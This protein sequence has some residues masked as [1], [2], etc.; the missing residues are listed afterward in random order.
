MLKK[1]NN[2]NLSKYSYE[3]IEK[4][5]E[6]IKNM[7][8]SKYRNDLKMIKKIIVKNN[9]DI[10]MIKNNNGYFSPDFETLTHK[11]Y[12]ELTNYFSQMDNISKN[13]N[14]NFS[15][16]HD[17]KNVSEIKIEKKYKYTNSENHILNKIKYEKALNQHRNECKNMEINCSKDNIFKKK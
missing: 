16:S 11:T 8:D 14:K 9:P 12:E 4:I 13:N 10:T 17:D 1:D 15:Q 6:R 2:D 5:A 7:T 3:K